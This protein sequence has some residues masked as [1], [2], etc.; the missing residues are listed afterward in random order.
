MDEERKDHFAEKVGDIEFK[1]ATITRKGN[2]FVA[3]GHAVGGGWMRVEGQTFK[4]VTGKQRYI[5]ES[6]ADNQGVHFSPQ[7]AAASI[8]NQHRIPESA[9]GSQQ[10][11]SEFAH[12]FVQEMHKL[13]SQGADYIRDIHGGGDVSGGLGGGANF[14]GGESGSEADKNAPKVNAGAH[15]GAS[16][17]IGSGYRA[18]SRQNIDLQYREVMKVLDKYEN[19][20]SG[21]ASAAQELRNMYS[22]NANNSGNRFL[23]FANG[24]AYKP[25]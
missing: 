7:A 25:K 1:D 3:E 18:Q 9:M 23:D 2:N 19:T 21:R 10:A 13:R 15:A 6:T 22:N 20:S 16:L 11:K 4:D 14:G 8:L 12:A 17:K 24:G 5:V